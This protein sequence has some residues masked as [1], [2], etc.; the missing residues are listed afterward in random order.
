[1]KNKTN[2][3]KSNEDDEKHREAEKTYSKTLTE[4]EEMRLKRPGENM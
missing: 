1:M 4:K 2:E 3:N